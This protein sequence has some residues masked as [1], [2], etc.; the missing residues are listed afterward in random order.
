[1]ITARNRDVRIETTTEQSK[2]DGLNS[3]ELDLNR[4][5]GIDP[6]KWF[7]LLRYALHLQPFN[8]LGLAHG[9]EVKRSTGF[10]EVLNGN[11]ISDMNMAKITSV[12]SRLR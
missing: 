3:S 1:M 8:E 10:R 7:F 6:K 11:F 9:I 4:L 2:D 5:S 12:L